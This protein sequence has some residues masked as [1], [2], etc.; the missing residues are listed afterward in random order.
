M[1]FA[2][3]WYLPRC[4]VT[5]PRAPVEPPDSP[6]PRDLLRLSIGLEDPDEL[7][8]DLRAALA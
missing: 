4:C 8:D 6:V 5:K 7:I 2:H 1:R 3:S